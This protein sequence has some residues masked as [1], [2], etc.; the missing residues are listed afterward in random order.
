MSARIFAALLLLAGLA[1]AQEQ[2]PAMGDDEPPS[3]AVRDA[4]T[5]VQ[6][7]APPE[8]PPL[9]APPR[10]EPRGRPVI[11]VEVLPGYRRLLGSDWLGTSADLSIGGEAKNGFAVLM[12]LGI[13][14]GATTFG[15]TFQHWTVAA[16]FVIP[17]GTRLR[18]ELGHTFGLLVLELPHTDDHYA[19]SPTMGA[20]LAPT[21]DLWRKQEQ[22]VFLEARLSYDWVLADHASDGNALTCQL[23]LGVAF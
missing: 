14:A 5:L 18:I 10:R 20:F 22:R 7:E 12:R 21:I 17:T 4:A 23:G 13:F 2:P 3:Q 11:A 19:E 15:V 6:P 9:V 16:A 8:P 1:R